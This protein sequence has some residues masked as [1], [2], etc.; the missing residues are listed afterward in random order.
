MARLRVRLPRLSDLSANSVLDYA[1]YKREGQPP[2]ETGSRPLHA[3]G[4][5]WKGS[6]MEAILHPAD[7]S[8]MTASLPP[9]PAGQM[10]TAVVGM[11][12]PYL[13]GDLANLAVGHGKRTAAGRIA[14]TW[15]DRDAAGSARDILAAAGLSLRALWPAPFLLPLPEDGWTAQWAHGYVVVRTD[16]D[17]GFVMPLDADD[18]LSESTG[19]GIERLRG[20]ISLMAPRQV[21]W[22]DAIPAW[23]PALGDTPATTFPPDACWAAPRAPWAIGTSEFGLGAAV[24]GSGWGRAAAWCGVAALTW[25][26]G[27]NLYAWRLEHSAQALQ[28]R[29][30]ERVREA[31][32]GLRTVID[33][34]RQARQQRDTQH[35]TNVS[36]EAELAFLLNVARET[37]TFAEGQIRAVRYTDGALELDL[38]RGAAGQAAATLAVAAATPPATDGRR[39]AASSNPPRTDQAAT[40]EWL[41]PLQQA[42]V[43]AEAIP[44]GWRLRRAAP[45]TAAERM[46]P[47]SAAALARSMP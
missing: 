3:L 2:I 45:D 7:A 40:P 5:R 14:I 30:V 16:A 28:A 32:P 24:R 1:A 36:A 31:F 12:E 37:M 34:L 13:L 47:S 38:G 44:T 15:T 11:V 22:L 25:M 19:L 17:N 29:N 43:Q 21:A 23:W 8:M 6:V 18:A 26:A 20:Q 42:G 9:L 41:A 33:P 4:Q 39:H 46:P 27:L 10:R 35:A